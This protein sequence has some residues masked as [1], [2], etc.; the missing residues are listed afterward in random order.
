MHIHKLINKGKQAP[1]L[2]YAIS[3]DF[4]VK[5]A[6]SALGE[7]K[8]LSYLNLLPMFCRAVPLTMVSLSFKKERTSLSQQQYFFPDEEGM[9]FS[10]VYLDGKQTLFL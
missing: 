8:K 2:P 4:G 3:Q 10:F 5:L 6:A 7:V 9:A 1:C